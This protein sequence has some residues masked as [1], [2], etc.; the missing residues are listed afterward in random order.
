MKHK[1]KRV[2]VVGGSRGLGRAAA[3]ALAAEG[4][5]VV[6]GY[7]SSTAEADAVVEGIRANGGRASAIGG[8]TSSPSEMES[9]VSRSVAFLGGIDIFVNSAGI[10]CLPGFLEVSAAE[11]QRTLDVNLTGAFLAG[12]AIAREMVRAGTKGIIVNIS[13]G[14]AFNASR[15]MTPYKVSKAGV[16]MLTRLMA[17]ELASYGIRV[18]S[19]A[20]G[21]IE[22]DINR[23]RL[24]DPDY[25][26]ARLAQIPMQVI[27]EPADIAAGLLYLVS[28]EARLV[29]G[30]CLRIDGGRA[31]INR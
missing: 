7:N 3:E 21:L 1:D 6:V 27:G 4:A 10:M 24:A 31:A 20:P 12:Q 5:A 17:L 23:E 14:G 28:D 11:W 16:E 2:V 9:F 22:T 19:I 30:L 29:S 26:R 15:G 13:S 25:R 8:D 18:N